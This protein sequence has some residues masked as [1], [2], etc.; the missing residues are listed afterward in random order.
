M[1]SAT[2]LGFTA[3]A[4]TTTS[5]LPQAVKSIITIDTVGIC[6]DIYSLFTAGSLLW[7]LFGV[8]SNNIPIAIANAVTLLFAVLLLIYKIQIKNLK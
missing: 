6:R 7:L 8:F 5:F 4:F 1:I 3:A 2:I